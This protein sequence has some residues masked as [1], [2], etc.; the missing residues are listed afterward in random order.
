MKLERETVNADGRM[1][2]YA[3]SLVAHY[4]GIRQTEK[5]AAIV[6]RVYDMCGDLS[7]LSAERFKAAVLRVAA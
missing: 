2:N 4:T 6:A 1:L 3:E 5:C 7:G